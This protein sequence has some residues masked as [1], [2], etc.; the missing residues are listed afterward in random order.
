MQYLRAGPSYRHLIF[1]PLTNAQQLHSIHFGLPNEWQYFGDCCLRVSPCYYRTIL[2]RV[3]NGDPGSPLVPI[4]RGPH[5]I[6]IPHSP[7]NKNMDSSEF[8]RIPHPHPMFPEVPEEQNQAYFKLK[9]SIF[10]QTKYN[11]TEVPI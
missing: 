9:W 6:F 8:L 5:E 3:Y 1:W 2:T 4:P 11:L 7:R 10:V